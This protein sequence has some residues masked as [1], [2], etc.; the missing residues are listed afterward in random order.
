MRLGNRTISVNLG[1]PNPVGAVWNRTLC[2]NLRKELVCPR[3]IH[4]ASYIQSPQPG[5]CGLEPHRNLWN[6]RP[7]I[8]FA[9]NMVRFGNCPLSI[10]LGVPNPVGAV[11]NRTL[12]VNLRKELVCP[13]A[14]HSASYIQRKE[15]L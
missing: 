9:N 14:V 7:I 11:W 15:V 6:R 13:R 10:N 4:C 3:A 12:C 5:R 8:V 1:V 2:V